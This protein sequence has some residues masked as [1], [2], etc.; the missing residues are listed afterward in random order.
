MLLLSMVWVFRVLFSI[1]NIQKNNHLLDEKLFSSSWL[2][3][4]TDI[5]TLE[6]DGEKVFNKGRGKVE[7]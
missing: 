6:C 2:V 3:Q 5:C 7:S 4:M 1:A